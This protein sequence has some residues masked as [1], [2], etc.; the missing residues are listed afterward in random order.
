MAHCIDISLPYNNV[1]LHIVSC[2]FCV[3]PSDA[4]NG[5]EDIQCEVEINGTTPSTS[6]SDHP[7]NPELSSPSSTV[8]H[9]C[10][11][12]W[13]Q[14][15]ILQNRSAKLLRDNVA[16]RRRLKAQ[17]RKLRILSKRSVSVNSGVGRC[18]RTDQLK[19]LS[20]KSTRGVKWSSI[21]IKNGLKLHFTCGP[22]G[23]AEL[24]AQNYP[25]PSRRTLLIP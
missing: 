9:D 8:C 12:L 15:Q 2:I 4:I 3:V 7:T 5:A 25:L 21:T 13:S 20:R 14:N 11:A 16:L 10:S 22:T 18:L 23:Y 6:R 19:A 1:N 17:S 24:L